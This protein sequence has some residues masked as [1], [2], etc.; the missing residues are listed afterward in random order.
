MM[1]VLL[2][3]GIAIGFVVTPTIAIFLTP[4]AGDRHH[5]R[6]PADVMQRIDFTLPR[7][8]AT[9]RWLTNREDMKQ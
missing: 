1:T 2:L 4:A 3:V 7:S 5:P 6:V 9:E 8:Q